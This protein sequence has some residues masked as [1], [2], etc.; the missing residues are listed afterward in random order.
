MRFGGFIA[1]SLRV[2]R[3]TDHLMLFAFGTIQ[4]RH[5]FTWRREWSWHVHRSIVSTA[6]SALLSF[7]TARWTSIRT[8]IS[9]L[10]YVACFLGYLSRKCCSAPAIDYLYLLK[11]G[12]T[13][14]NF[15]P[16]EHQYSCIQEWYSPDIDMSCSPDWN[17]HLSLLQAGYISRIDGEG[18]GLLLALEIP[19]EI[20]DLP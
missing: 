9:G 17:L 2:R 3:G 15:T 11:R 13:S 4:R 1:L 14:A 10:T 16:A 20:S 7:D 18:V 6:A 19:V 8:S 12:I 5:G